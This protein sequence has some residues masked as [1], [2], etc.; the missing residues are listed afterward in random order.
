M[1]DQKISQDPSA[2][3]LDG[4]EVVPVV[5]AGVNK[6]TTVDDIKDRVQATINIDGGSA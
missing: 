5:A 3:T 2:G 6:K 4:T 1:P